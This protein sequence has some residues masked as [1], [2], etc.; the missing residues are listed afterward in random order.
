MNR[1]IAA[2][3]GIAPKKASQWILAESLGLD[4]GP[5]GVVVAYYHRCC[6]R[7]VVCPAPRFAREIAL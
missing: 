1:V 4:L 3:V 6:H 2:F 5:R 7:Q